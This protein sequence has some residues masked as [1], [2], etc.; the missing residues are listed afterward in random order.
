MN[1][2][3]MINKNL[4]DNTFL[5]DNIILSDKPIL[6][7]KL[8]YNYRKRLSNEN[9]LNII[10]NIESLSTDFILL[11]IISNTF[12]DIFN[13]HTITNTTINIFQ[14]KKSIKIKIIR[15][16][17][18]YQ[19]L[20][21]YILDNPFYDCKM[22]QKTLLYFCDYQRIYF[23]LLKL[24]NR[25][26]KRRL[27][28]ENN[29]IN[30][31]DLLLTSLK[32]I[33]DNNKIKIIQN[34]KLFIF[35]INDIYNLVKEGLFTNDYMIVQP[36]HPINPYINK[37]FCLSHMYLFRNKL[38]QY[39]N[40][41]YYVHTYLDNNF[42][43]MYFRVAHIHL[44]QMNAIRCYLKTLSIEAKISLSL[45]IITE[46]FELFPSKLLILDN[47]LKHTIYE[48]IKHIIEYDVYI[49]EYNTTKRLYNK[50][51]RIIKHNIQPVLNK[52][53]LYFEKTKS[54]PSPSSSP[55]PSPSSSPTHSTHSTTPSSPPLTL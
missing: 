54:L 45:N 30:T 37:T 49:I 26:L 22:K 46:Y 32:D 23:T 42:N 17:M 34:N 18:K 2:S 16:K 35:S 4:S 55:S 31:T 28:R 15:Y 5:S 8:Y 13:I 47:E 33:P 19:N 9:K 40:T 38:K 24:K 12:Y 52:Y 7:D 51:I 27:I 39:N 48:S 29:S 50:Y 6:F 21:T 10:N 44:L 41:S 20:K 11:P 53:K 25:I 43:L 3:V 14:Q 1:N 36:R